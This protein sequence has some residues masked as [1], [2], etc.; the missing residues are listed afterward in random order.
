M[1]GGDGKSEKKQWH[2]LV[3]GLIDLVGTPML[4]GSI[5]LEPA[6]WRDIDGFVIGL[7]LMDIVTLFLFFPIAQS[8]FGI[9]CFCVVDCNQHILQDEL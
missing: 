6:F 9:V 7:I 2:T 1:C 8:I 4:T 5:M 3:I